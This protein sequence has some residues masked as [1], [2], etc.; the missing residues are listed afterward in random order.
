ML[1]ILLQTCLNLGLLD[2]GDNGVLLGLEH[3]HLVGHGLLG[4]HL[5]GRVERQ[6]NVNL[7]AKDTLAEEHVAHGGVDEVT[8]WVTS[9]DHVSVAE[10]HALSTL[11]PELPRHDNL[12]PECTALHDEAEHTV[13]GPAD[14]EASEELVTEGLSLSLFWTTAVS[15]RM[16]RPFSPRTFW[17][18]VARMMISWRAGVWRTSTPE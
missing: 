15:S 9:L 5:A 4:A 7:D 11:C 18:R 1:Q 3:I 14:G 17:V 8:A 12:T 13:A 6:H 2:G 10:L 16:R